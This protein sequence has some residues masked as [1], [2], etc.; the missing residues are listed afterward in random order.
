M[1]DGGHGQTASKRM[2]KEGVKGKI[3]FVSSLLGYFSMVGWSAYS[4]GKFALRGAS[5]LFP[6]CSR[7][8]L[9]S[10]RSHHGVQASPSL[11]SPSF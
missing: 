7:P 10:T 9:T 8:L 2:V 6:S 5:P 11:Y 1:R 4:P 3:V